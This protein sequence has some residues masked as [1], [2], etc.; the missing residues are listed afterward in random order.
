MMNNYKKLAL[1]TL[2]IGVLVIASIVIA[3][4]KPATSVEAY[5]TEIGIFWKENT[6]TRRICRYDLATG[7]DLLQNITRMKELIALE[8]TRPSMTD[9]VKTTRTNFTEQEKTVIFNK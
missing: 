3:Q 5:Y 4:S 7:Q 2:I 9:R 1:T 6:T 8:K